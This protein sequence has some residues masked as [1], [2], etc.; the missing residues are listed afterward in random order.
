MN[1]D[2]RLIRF[3][4]KNGSVKSLFDYY[5]VLNLENMIKIN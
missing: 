3:R 5:G 2:I 1:K 4:E